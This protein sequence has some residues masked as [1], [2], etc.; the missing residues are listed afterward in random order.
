MK[1]QN[2]VSFARVCIDLSAVIGAA[3]MPFEALAS[4]LSVSVPRPRGPESAALCMCAAVPVRATSSSPCPGPTVGL[5]QPGTEQ[6]HPA[7]SPRMRRVFS[8]KSAFCRPATAPSFQKRTCDSNLPPIFA[9]LK[10]TIVEAVSD[11]QDIFQRSGQ[12]CLAV[13][14]PLLP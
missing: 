10:P 14:C 13:S 5:L 6:R 11:R 12:S 1:C 4:C 2:G 8:L 3:P 9:R 7:L